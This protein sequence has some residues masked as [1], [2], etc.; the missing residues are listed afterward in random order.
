MIEEARIDNNILSNVPSEK[1]IKIF[2][3]NSL[4]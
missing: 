3:K 2:D 1:L 4:V